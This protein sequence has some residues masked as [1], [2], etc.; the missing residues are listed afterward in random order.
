M[1]EEHGG[2]SEVVAALHNYLPQAVKYEAWALELL[3]RGEDATVAV[4]ER[5][6]AKAH[7]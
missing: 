7:R 4:Y 6:N 2:W 1:T 5:G 3:A